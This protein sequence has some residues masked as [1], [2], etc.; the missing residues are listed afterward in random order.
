MLFICFSSQE[1]PHVEVL[2]S[3]LELNFT[4]AKDRLLG[5]TFAEFSSL[6]HC[7]LSSKSN[8]ALNLL[9]LIKNRGVYLNIIDQSIISEKMG[10]NIRD[11]H[12][13][14][15]SKEEVIDAIHMS[16]EEVYN[17]YKNN[18]KDLAKAVVSYLFKDAKVR[19][20]FT[21]EV[22]AHRQFAY[23]VYIQLLL[24]KISTTLTEFSYYERYEYR[25]Y[26]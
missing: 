19:E 25:S 24:A 6:F 3:L 5:I 16:L 4:Y 13:I 10:K 22:N 17:K 20:I 8:F 15:I 12:I 23:F 11:R 26:I 9:N 2:H 18:P 14:Q 1:L 7:Q 21:E